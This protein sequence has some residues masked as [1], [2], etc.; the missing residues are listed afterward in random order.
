MPPPDRLRQIPSV[1]SLLQR[2][3][4]RSLLAH[5][6][7]AVVLTAMRKLLDECRGEALRE[8]GPGRP[9]E[10][11]ISRLLAALPR[12]VAEGEEI[13]L[14]RVINATGIVVH[15]N[16]GRAPLS[17]E[18]VRAVTVTAAVEPALIAYTAMQ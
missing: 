3:E 18:A 1:A 16:L 10:E 2:D 11:W 6:P 9:R 17:E 14:Q 13:T 12:A 7:R 15:T 8:K 5:Y 4:I